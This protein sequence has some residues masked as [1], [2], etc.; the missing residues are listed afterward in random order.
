MSTIS[1]RAIPRG[2]N[3]IIHGFLAFEWQIDEGEPQHINVKAGPAQEDNV[4]QD[5]KYTEGALGVCEAMPK[6]DEVLNECV[7][8]GMCLRIMG[9][10]SGINYYLAFAKRQNIFAR[11]WASVETVHNK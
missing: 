1:V 6:F 8:K 11:K 2:P 7:A 9:D 4:K 3:M 10:V 5:P